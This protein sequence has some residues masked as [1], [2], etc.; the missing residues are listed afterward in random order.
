MVNFNLKVKMEG[1]LRFG[2]SISEKNNELRLFPVYYCTTKSTD[3]GQTN[4]KQFQYQWVNS[5]FFEQILQSQNK[6]S[7]EEL[8]ADTLTAYRW[9]KYIEGNGIV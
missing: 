6:K 3:S 1:V 5:E 4:D 9:I 8:D 2:F 7:M